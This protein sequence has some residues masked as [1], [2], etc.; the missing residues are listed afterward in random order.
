MRTRR[1]LIA[2]VILFLT[3]PALGDTVLVG[4]PNGLNSSWAVISH[5]WLAMGFTLNT[6]VNVT[7]LTA[8]VQNWDPGST[9]VITFQLTD[10][11]SSSATV[12]GTWSVSPG[13]NVETETLALGTMLGPGNYFL[14]ATGFGTTTGWWGSDSVRVGSYGTVQSGFWFTGSND[15]DNGWLF[16]PDS[17]YPPLM[18]S[19]EGSP[20]VPE[21]ASMVL[22]GTGL[23]A[24]AG[25]LRGKLRR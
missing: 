25:A 23:V 16:A 11:I 20:A 9:D 15:L 6:A 21:P 8:T 18:F 12:Y 5:Q 1:L 22:F 7:Q 10:A 4:T 17:P 19:V 3:S 14:I 24:L 2:F 13:A